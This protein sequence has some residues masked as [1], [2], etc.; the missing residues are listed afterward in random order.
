[1]NPDY[2]W[3]SGAVQLLTW[4]VVGPLL[5]ILIAH[6]AWRGKLRNVDSKRYAMPCIASG[7]FSF[8][9]I[10]LAKWMNSDIRST[11][12]FLQLACVLL[13]GLSFGICMGCGFR[14][15]LGLWRWHKTT[16]LYSRQN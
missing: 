12:Y 15:L 10:G 11:A 14:I 2:L 7:I 1:M 13:G 3:L 9:L 16:R 6:A 4:F 8:L 5:A